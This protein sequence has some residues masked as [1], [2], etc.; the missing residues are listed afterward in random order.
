MRIASPR[1]ADIFIFDEKTLPSTI[2]TFIEDDHVSILEGQI[3]PSDEIRSDQSDSKPNMPHSHKR[4]TSTTILAANP[5][6]LGHGR[7]V[8]SRWDS[9]LDIITGRG[10]ELIVD[11]Q[12]L[13][14]A[15]V[16]AVAR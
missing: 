1:S 15:T 9:F 6:P 10:Q 2:E 8:L 12:S 14:P 13:D 5:E 16:V 7:L 4:L 3:T 11:G